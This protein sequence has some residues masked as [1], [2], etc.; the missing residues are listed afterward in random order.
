[1]LL[2]KRFKKRFK[3]LKFIWHKI[4]KNAAAA[5]KC[6]Y[7]APVKNVKEFTNWMLNGKFQRY[8]LKI[9]DVPNRCYVSPVE[10]TTDCIS[11]FTAGPSFCGRACFLFLFNVQTQ[12]LV[13]TSINTRLNM[14]AFK[15]KT[16][17]CWPRNIGRFIRISRNLSCFAVR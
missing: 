17:S 16:S 13:Y 5:L 1:M 12:K 7:L 10:T 14:R 4:A 15:N 11:C 9:L 3:T 8:L 6:G 2:K